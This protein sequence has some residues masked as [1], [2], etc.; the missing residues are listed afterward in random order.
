MVAYELKVYCV[1]L[2]RIVKVVYMD[3]T[4]TNRYAILICTDT[5]LCGAKVIE[6]Y[7][8]RFQIEFLIRDAKQYTGLE[9]CQARS[10]VKLYNHFNMSMKAV[11]LMKYKY[12]ATLK[13]KNEVPFSIRSIKTWFY[14]K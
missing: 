11:S 12:W 10:E 6:Y 4:D 8:L 2:K 9:E 7:Q 3:F 14:N 5:E 13:D 1:T